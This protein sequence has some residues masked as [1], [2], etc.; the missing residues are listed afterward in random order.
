MF[1][2]IGL[3]VLSGVFHLSLFGGML[4]ANWVFWAEA[5]GVWGFGTFWLV[6][7]QEVRPD[8]PFLMHSTDKA[9]RGL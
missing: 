9:T 6:K 4:R 2:G 7:T 8:L 3:A 1:A 5:F